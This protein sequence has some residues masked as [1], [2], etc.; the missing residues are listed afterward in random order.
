MYYSTKRQQFLIDQG[1]AFKVITSLKGME[2]FPNLAYRE[3]AEQQELLTAVL[4]ANE[5]DADIA[6]DVKH[7]EGDLAGTVTSTKNIGFPSAKRTGGSLFALSG[8]GTMGYIEKN[9]S[10]NK[11]LK[12]A[13]GEARHRL[14]KTRDKEVQKAR[15]EAK[16][17]QQ[18]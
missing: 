2:S 16:K 4:L 1:Y 17:A 9:K 10:V 11:G 7:V 3:K 12:N 15:K 13:G 6:S 18:Q 14:F 8:A 5:R